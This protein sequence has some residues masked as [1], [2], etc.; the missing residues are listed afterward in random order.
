M[1]VAKSRERDVNYTLAVFF[2]LRW[3]GVPAEKIAKKL[4]FDSVEDMH[5]QLENWKIPEWLIR[6]NVSSVKQRARE[7]STPPTRETLVRAKSFHPLVMLPTSLG[8]GLSRCSKASSYSSTWT[9][10][11]VAGNSSAKTWK[12]LPYCS[13][14]N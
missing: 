12:R 4:E 14:G 9:K 3:E 2:G 11:F 8:S 1:S 10:V 13:P 5:I 7:K 6:A